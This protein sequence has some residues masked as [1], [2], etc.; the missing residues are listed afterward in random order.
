MTL[1]PGSSSVYYYVVPGG[2][3]GLVFNNGS[4]S[5]TGDLTAIPNH[6]YSINGDQGE[7]S[8]TGIGGVGA[9]ATA[10]IYYNMQGIR[11]LNPSDGIY[12]VRRGNVV[13]KEY[14]R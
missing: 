13:T 1:C 9:D 7:H 10:P 3:T 5:Q 8:D 14:V 2:T 12:I 6:I 4:G 11:V